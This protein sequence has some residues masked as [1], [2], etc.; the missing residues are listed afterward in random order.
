MRQTIL[1][2]GE[3]LWDLLPDGAVVGGAPFNFAYRAHSLGDAAL[4]VTR[5]GRDDLGH[6]AWDQIVALGVDTRFVQWD[7]E[8]PTGTVEVSFDD[9]RN[10]DY[11]IVPGVAY[12]NLAVTE[13]LLECAA[14]ADCICY[15]TLAQRTPTG[16]RTLAAILER[17]PN[18]R[19]LLDI[20]LR[21]KC[22]TAESVRASLD[23]ADV[24][25]LNEDE[26]RDVAQ[27]L[28]LAAE[29]LAGFA[30]AVMDRCGLS[31]CVIT[32]GERGALASGREGGTA[33]IPGYRASLVD[34]CGSGDAFTAGFL[35]L[36]LR[37]RPLADCCELG[38]A[39][40]AMVAAQAGAT[41]PISPD[42]VRKFLAQDHE[43]T[44][45]PE[46]KNMALVRRRWVWQ[47]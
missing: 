43:R 2:Y 14:T 23:A 42:D 47:S 40:G 30:D 9:D 20:N 15:G 16:R 25:K 17:S 31:H 24:L 12:D 32:C 1:S 27:M 10:P 8:V 33:Y 11:Y 36:L 35:H 37:G 46:L 7:G 19:K 28:G 26:A 4:I 41:V 39:L 13:P 3:T 18:S 6:R 21:K 29:P 38:N 45:E 44:I 5:L 22:Y 34:P